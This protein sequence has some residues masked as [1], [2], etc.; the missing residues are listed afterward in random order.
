[1]GRWILV[2]RRRRGRRIA[3]LESI[4]RKNPQPHCVIIRQTA[5]SSGNL[6]RKKNYRGMH[7]RY[8]TR[9]S[10]L[11]VLFASADRRHAGIGRPCGRLA[12]SLHLD[13]YCGSHKNEVAGKAFNK[14]EPYPLG[15]DF[16]R[17][18]HY[19]GRRPYSFSAFDPFNTRKENPPRRNISWSRR[20]QVKMS[21][22]LRDTFLKG[23]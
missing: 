20:R 9:R 6:S 23:I 21:K 8:V 1:M 7:D 16:E 12:E 15:G 19:L 2:R 18:N 3:A 5:P 4:D 13:R 17:C 22:H 14:T 10:L 11:V